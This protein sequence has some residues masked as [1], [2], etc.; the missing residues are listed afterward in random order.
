M[1]AWS[2]MVTEGEKI[3]MGKSIMYG[4]VDRSICLIAHCHLTCPFLQQH[5]VI[6]LLLRQARIVFLQF[7][8]AITLTITCW[9]REINLIHRQ[10]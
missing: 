8:L 9:K 2:M 6:Y 1:A 3:H 7:P 10:S 5:M 4:Y